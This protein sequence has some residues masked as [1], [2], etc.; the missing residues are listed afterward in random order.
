MDVAPHT[1]GVLARATR[2]DLRTRR[3]RLA[4]LDDCARFAH[5]LRCPGPQDSED[6]DG[7][8]EGLL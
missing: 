1:L 6:G 2:S 4:W 3:R 8:C 5:H 7:R